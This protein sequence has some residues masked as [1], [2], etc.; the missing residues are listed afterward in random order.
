VKKIIEEHGG[1]LAL[2]DAPAFSDGAHQGA[3]AVVRLPLMCARQQQE[4]ERSEQVRKVLAH[5]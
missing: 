3:M 5:E 4:F 1:T 2:E